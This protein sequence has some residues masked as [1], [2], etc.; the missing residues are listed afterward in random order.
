MYYKKNENK[1]IHNGGGTLRK[2]ADVHHDMLP[3]ELGGE[4]CVKS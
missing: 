1:K 2:L 3:N 4:S